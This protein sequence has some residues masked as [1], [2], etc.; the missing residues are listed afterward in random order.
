M[1]EEQAYCHC[2]LGSHHCVDCRCCCRRRV[3]WQD[4]TV[5]L[6]QHLH[7][8][9]ACRRSSRQQPNGAGICAGWQLRTA[10]VHLTSTIPLLQGVLG[11]ATRCISGASRT[12]ASGQVERPHKLEV[13][14]WNLCELRGCLVCLRWQPGGLQACPKHGKVATCAPRNLPMPAGASFS[15]LLPTLAAQVAERSKG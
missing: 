11:Q 5:L 2:D 14:H 3:L 1:W 7:H 10:G 9:N 15:L 8:A 13:G 4:C 12:H 6:P